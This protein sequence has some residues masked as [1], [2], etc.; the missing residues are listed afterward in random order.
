M[1]IFKYQGA[2]LTGGDGGDIVSLAGFT[3][4]VTIQGHLVC[5][6][7]VGREAEAQILIAD[8]FAAEQGA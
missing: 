7:P 6:V 4:D 8:G 5:D 1:K 3:W 2:T